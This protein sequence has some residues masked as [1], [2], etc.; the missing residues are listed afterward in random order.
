[1]TEGAGDIMLGRGQGIHASI[2]YLYF[3][4]RIRSIKVYS[5]L[6]GKCDAEIDKEMFNK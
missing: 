4:E 2:R 1:M 6:L 3:L 5:V